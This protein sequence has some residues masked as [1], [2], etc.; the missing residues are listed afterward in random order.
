MEHLRRAL[1]LIDSS[2]Y[3]RVEKI[4][5]IYE[6]E[7][8]GNVE[9]DRFLNGAA[10][11]QTLLTPPKLMDALLKIEGELKRERTIHWGPRTIDLDIIFYDDIISSDPHIILPHPGVHERL[12]VLK[13]LCDIAPALLH[14]LRKE[15]CCGLARAL[16][17]KQEEPRLYKEAIEPSGPLKP[18]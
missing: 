1:K 7:P 4:S 11:I 2:Q 18:L 15:S 12:F 6:T 3:C 9:Q 13:P 5:P 16:E 14:P 8:Y 10:E 17:G